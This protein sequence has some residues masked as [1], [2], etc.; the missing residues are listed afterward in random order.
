MK[1]RALRKII[2]IFGD[3][4]LLLFAL[5]ISLSIRKGF[6]PSFE[7]FYNFAKSFLWLFL[8]WIF[9]LFIFDFYSLKLK[10]GTFRFFRYFFIF[11]FLSIFSGILYFYFSQ[12]LQYLPKQFCFYKQLFFASF[13]WFGG[14][15]LTSCL[16]EEP[17]K[18]ELYSQ[19]L[20]QNQK[21]YFII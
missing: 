17:D 1:Y 19:V 7:E 9:L 14:F 12:A 3:I 11:I 13:F 20:R 4:F 5:F 8:F 2:L 18:K 15:S 21:N 10:V 16:K 6:P